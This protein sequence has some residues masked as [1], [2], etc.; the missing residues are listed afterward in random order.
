VLVSFALLIQNTGEEQI[1]KKKGLF[2]LMVKMVL[3]Y[4]WLALLFWDLW[5]GRKSW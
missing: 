4:G 2:W 5:Q 3:V 1:K